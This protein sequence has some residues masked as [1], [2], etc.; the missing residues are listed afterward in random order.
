ME[1]ARWFF[2]VPWLIRSSTSV[3]LV[4]HVS[5]PNYARGEQRAKCGRLVASPRCYNSH[6]SMIE[7]PHEEPPATTGTLRP[8]IA[9]SKGRSAC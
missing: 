2:K 4:C 7:E 8:A 9:P 6:G 3:D 1:C 5:R